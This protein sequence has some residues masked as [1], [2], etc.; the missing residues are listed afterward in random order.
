MRR[1]GYEQNQCRERSEPYILFMAG[2][3]NLVFVD[4]S[5]DGMPLRTLILLL[6]DFLCITVYIYKREMELPRWK[7][8]SAFEKVMAAMLGMSAVALAYMA[9]FES[10]HF[11]AGVDTVALLL[12]YPC[13]S[14]RK[15][16]PQDIFCVYSAC[17]SLVCIL[18][19]VCYLTGGIGET[20]IALLLENNA[21][22]PWLVLSIT[23]NIT[24]YCFQERGQIWYGVN[25]VL[26][27]FLLAVEKNL[28]G[29][30][31][32]ALVPLMLPIFCRP[33]KVLVGRAAQAAL[34]YAFLVCNMSLVAGYVP[35]MEGIVIYDLEISVYM[36]LI[37]AAM[38]VWFFEYWDRYA[39]GV[40]EDATI[41]EMRAWCRKA[42][43]ACLCGCVGI[44]AAA[45]FFRNAEGS[46]LHRV[47]Q[48]IAGEIEENFVWSAGLFGQMGNRFG[49]WGIT[50]VCLL[51]YMGITRIRNTRQ[52]HVKAHKMY[53]M[54]AAVCL[55]QALFL[56]QTMVSLP[57]Y[58][59]FFFLFMQTEEEPRQ[60]TDS[61]GGEQNIQDNATTDQKKGDDADEA[62]YS[63]P[64]LQRGG[65]AGDCAE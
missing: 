7:T 48:I 4:V 14:G 21:I 24:A 17:S 11:W 60:K 1:T 2:I 43:T 25:I 45:K 3:Y 34:M 13:I 38:G 33:S 37:L 57:V 29:M 8:C 53:R 58:A 28:F 51:F 30:A 19:A 12:V 42:V 54:I 18:A 52:W 36:E 39:R 44:L 46:S 40:D 27:A 22:V 23:M 55:M 56:P 10:D 5:I 63:D 9:L 6:A 49:I 50:A 35:L 65:D 32:A 26:N 47:A 41:P 59:V 61:D 64:M 15:R 20:L 31:V 16:F 62:D